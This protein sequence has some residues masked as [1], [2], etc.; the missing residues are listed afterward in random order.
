MSPRPQHTTAQ[1]EEPI[2]ANSTNNLPAVNAPNG[3]DLFKK[4]G[5]IEDAWADLDDLD[6]APGETQIPVIKI[7]RK[8]DGT[9]GIKLSGDDDVT[10]TI[11]FVWAARG[12]SRVKFAGAY[13]PKADVTIDC[14]STD[15]LAPAPAQPLWA[16]A[17]TADGKPDPAQ[18]YTQ[19]VSCSV[20]PH[21]FE[22][23][24]SGP[25]ACKKSMEALA[26]L[27]RPGTTGAM[28]VARF[29]FGGLAYKHA[30]N[31]WDS[32]R[33]R[34]PK[35][36]PVGVV[37]E[38][39]LEREQTP[40][41]IFFVPHFEVVDELSRPEAD[42]FITDARSRLPEWQAHIADDL[43]QPVADVA[44]DAG[45]PFADQPDPFT[46]DGRPVDTSSGEVYEGEV[47]DEA[48]YDVDVDDS[49]RYSA[50]QSA[51]F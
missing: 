47:V 24:A 43:D 7:A 23:G 14:R 13:D 5:Q 3:V 6:L 37:T 22:N 44:A 18:G 10:E 12:V 34:I 41:G 31:Y 21:S 38:M 20:C 9:G 11:R 29:R 48:D 33:Y 16:N 50:Q 40:N 32:F 27:Q 19:P 35:R 17:K 25:T 42:V 51:N 15:G 36:R 45:D 46:S 8:T 26:Y 1:R 4:L 2:M 49:S 28:D 30:R 39:T